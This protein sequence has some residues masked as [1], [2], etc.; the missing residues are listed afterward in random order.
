MMESTSIQKAKELLVAA[1]RRPCGH[2]SSY[3]CGHCEGRI[4][5]QVWLE[6]LDATDLFA[7]ATGAVEALI[8][9]KDVIYTRL[10]PDSPGAG[11]AFDALLEALA[12]FETL[13]G[14]G[15]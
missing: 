4:A 2:G 15:V 6:G 13:L 3:T 14:E 10:G 12:G 1:K 9:A 11:D 8:K 5:A 7:W